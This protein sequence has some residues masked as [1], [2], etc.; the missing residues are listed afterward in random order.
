MRKDIGGEKFQRS[1]QRRRQHENI[2]ERERERDGQEI[3]DADSCQKPEEAKDGF[4][5]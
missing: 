1:L 4:A 5:P 2:G 3:R